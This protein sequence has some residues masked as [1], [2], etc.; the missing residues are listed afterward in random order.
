MCNE[1]LITSG[2][3]EFDRQV[4]KQVD[5][6]IRYKVE[7]IFR[8]ID[9]FQEVSTG[10]G[11]Q[12]EDVDEDEDEDEDEEN[13][14][15]EARTDFQTGPEQYLI[16]VGGDQGDI[17]IIDRDASAIANSLKD[18]ATIISATV[19]V[20]LQWPKSCHPLTDEN[21]QKYLIHWLK[22]KG[23][24]EGSTFPPDSKERGFFFFS[25]I[26]FFITLI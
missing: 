2:S 21:F 4:L 10:M 11:N 9:K 19:H 22:E 8:V 25:S 13:K 26:N 14:E 3:E 23:Y 5:L 16:K 17:M 24:P 6:L 7:A 15:E 20:A 12:N 18:A 1:K